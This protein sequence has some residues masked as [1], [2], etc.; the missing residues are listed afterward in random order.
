MGEHCMEIE[1]QVSFYEQE[2][3]R[4]VSYDDVYRIDILNGKIKIYCLDGF[5]T[6]L[7]C[8]SDIQVSGVVV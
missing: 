6:F 4:M 7:D 2:R 1:T 5:V 8:P 3:N